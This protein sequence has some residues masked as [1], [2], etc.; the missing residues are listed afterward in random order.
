MSSGTWM[1]N[2]GL[3]LKFGTAKATAAKAGEY[4]Y[5][6]D[7]GTRVIE[8]RLDLTTVTAT[9]GSLIVEDN[10]FVPA[11]MIIEQVEVVADTAATGATAVLNLG[12]VALDRTTEIDFN[13]LIAA[14]PLASMDSAGEKTVLNVGSSYAGA[15][16][17]TTIG[18]SP[19]YL[20]ADYDTA[21]FSAGVVTIRI[22]YRNVATITQ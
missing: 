22:K 12:L 8:A 17:G 15:L 6:A 16:I 13:G 1:N 11:N 10:L 5:P 19:G 20:C 14:L 4:L 21:A 18:A 7:G 3:Y 9:N 2:D